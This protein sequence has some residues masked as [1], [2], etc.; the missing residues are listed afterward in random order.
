MTNTECRCGKPAHD[1]FVCDGC[2]DELAKALGDV[3]WLSEELEVTVSHQKGIDYRMVG[4]GSGGK[5]PSE[6]PSPVTWSAA[7]ARAHL[8]ALLVS[9]TLFCA[10]ENVRNSSPHIGLPDD[11]LAALSR[12]LMWRVNG[13]GLLE[14][15]AE[16]VDEITSAVAHCHRL[17]DRPADRQYLG[18]CDVCDEGRLYARANA[19]WARCDSCDASVDAEQTRTRLLASLDDRLCTAAEIAHLSTYLGLKAGRDQVRKRINQWHTRGQ[20]AEAHAFS[21]EPT[22]RF[23]TVY[24]KL[25]GAEY[26]TKVAG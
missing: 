24:E 18:A 16:A 2:S 26:G 25:V 23:G 13:L 14:I 7:D 3:P 17:I 1:A 19:A 12:W 4:G 8:K 5:K 22:F 20:I 10:D 11:N 6:R 21:D 9:W 15:G